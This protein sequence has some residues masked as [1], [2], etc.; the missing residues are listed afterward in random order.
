MKNFLFLVPIICLSSLAI[1]EVEAKQ[2][3]VFSG[4]T[5]WQVERAAKEAGYDYPDADMKCSARCR[6]RWAKD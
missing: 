1:H 4:K 3:K 5:V 2:T 6:Q